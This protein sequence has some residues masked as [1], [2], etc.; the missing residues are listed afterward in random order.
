MP[1][2][3]FSLR[4]CYSILRKGGARQV[5]DESVKELR[6]SI[7]DIAFEISKRAELIESFRRLND[8]LVED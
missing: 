2:V 1:E 5:S 3:K 4:H 8:I 7:E 6:K